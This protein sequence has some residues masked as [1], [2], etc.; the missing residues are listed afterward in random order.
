MMSFGYRQGSFSTIIASISPQRRVYSLLAAGLVAEMGWHLLAKYAKP[1]QSIQEKLAFK[2]D[3][4][5]WSQFW[6]G[7]LQLITVSMGAPVGREGAAREVSL[8]ITA[9]WTQHLKI[10]PKDQRL[11]L[12]CSSGAALGAVYNA[13][14]ATII[15]ILAT[16]LK[17]WSF[18]ACTPLQFVVL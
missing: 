6:H 16:I 18:R 5:P 13:P 2:R 3:F 9:L 11:L 8:A 14:L 4:C 10:T 1:T 17:K 15:F 12:A 7:W